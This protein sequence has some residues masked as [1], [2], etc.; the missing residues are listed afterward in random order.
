MFTAQNLVRWSSKGNC[1]GPVARFAML[2]KCI[3]VGDTSSHE[4][5]SRNLP[6]SSD[7][8]DLGTF[9]RYMQSMAKSTFLTA[10]LLAG[11]QGLTLVDL[12]KRSGLTCR[13]IRQF[14]GMGAIDRSNRPYSRACYD[15]SHLNQARRVCALLQMGL[16]AKEVAGV[17]AELAPSGRPGPALRIPASPGLTS[18]GVGWVACEVVLSF[19]TCCTGAEERLMEVVRQAVRGFIIREKAIRRCLLSI[20]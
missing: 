5:S 16:S 8:R 6:W 18:T 11:R 15:T 12:S 3:L 7:A 4:G 10:E 20:P 1:V 13:R 2:E 19:P 14:I 17:L 9:Y